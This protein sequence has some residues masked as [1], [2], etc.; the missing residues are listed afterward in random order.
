MIKLNCHPYSCEI[1]FTTKKSEFYR[2]RG[3]LTGRY[4]ES[5]VFG[6]CSCTENRGQ[7]VVGLFESDNS[8]LVHELSHAAI[9]A[10]EFMGMD[11]NSHTTEAFAYFI[12]S[13]H[14]QCT[15]YMN[16]QAL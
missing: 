12:E 11:I 16:K 8:M 15:A 7:M 3:N 4:S 13:L 10:F 6:M 5:D 2:K 14:R 9:N 1:W